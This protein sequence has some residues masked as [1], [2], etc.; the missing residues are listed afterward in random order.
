LALSSI[1]GGPFKSKIEEF[2]DFGIKE[3]I[4]PQSPIP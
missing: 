3:L 2:R 4:I 1:D